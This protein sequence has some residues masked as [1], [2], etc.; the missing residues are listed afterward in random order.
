MTTFEVL[1]RKYDLPYTIT[2]S[3]TKE[4]ILIEATLL[5][6]MKGYAAV[7]MRD[8]ADRVKITPGGLYNHF[9]SK[10]DLWGEVVEHLL[11]LYFLYHEHLTEE[12]EK[13]S[14]FDEV[15]DVMFDEPSRMKNLFTCYAFGLIQTEQFRD[16]RAAEIFAKVFLKYG[17]DFSRKWFDRCVERGLVKPFD[18]N[19]AAMI[20]VQTVYLCVNLKVHESLGRETSFDIAEMFADLKKFIKRA[21]G[22]E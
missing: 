15:L 6:A 14:T 8:I 11:K 18:T 13:A 1:G 12:L 19:T 7:S 20:F 22:A 3:Q 9:A 10:E 2:G 21:A 4:H 17:A 5:F 16:E